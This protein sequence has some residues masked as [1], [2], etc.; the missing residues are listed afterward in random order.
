MPDIIQDQD[1][2]ASD[3][4]IDPFQ[5][6]QLLSC[7]RDPDFFIHIIKMFQSQEQKVNL[8]SLSVSTTAMIQ[9]YYKLIQIGLEVL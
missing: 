8:L 9:I 6:D 1:F 7:S 5:V 3:L 4:I 2:Q